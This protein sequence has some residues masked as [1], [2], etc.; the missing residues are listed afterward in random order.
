MQTQHLQ[1]ITG[2]SYSTSSVLGT[3]WPI[4]KDLKA[5]IS[6]NRHTSKEPTNTCSADHF[7]FPEHTLIEPSQP[8]L[9]C[10]HE[11]Q[12]V[13]AESE[14]KGT[15]KSQQPEGGLQK[16]AQKIQT[17]CPRGT[18]SLKHNHVLVGR[19]EGI[20]VEAQRKSVELRQNLLKAMKCYNNPFR[21]TL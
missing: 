6:C 19:D 12:G 20:A 14:V 9:S 18:T 5:V 13:T 11:Q 8:G 21:I 4:P 16:K 17:Q 10:S 1:F 2:L 15:T 3:R 7:K